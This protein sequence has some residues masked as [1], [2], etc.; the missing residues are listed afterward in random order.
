[1]ASTQFLA[2]IWLDHHAAVLSS[3]MT[4]TLMILLPFNT[5]AF[6]LVQRD[7]LDSKR[8]QDNNDK[9]IPPYDRASLLAYYTFWWVRPTLATA[10][11]KNSLAMTDLP[12]LSKF[13]EP[14]LL[15][16]RFWVWWNRHGKAA[17]PF[18]LLVALIF[19]IQR[20]VFWNSFLHGILFL[21]CMFADPI[22]LNELLKSK[23]SFAYSMV[24]IAGLS[25]SMLVRVSCMEVCF[26]E[27]TRVANN[28]RT[29]LVLVIFKITITNPSES[30]R[31]LAGFLTNLMASDTEKLGQFS[32]GIFALAQWCF[33]VVT[34]PLNL[35]FLHGLV[36]NGAFLAIGVLA[37]GGLLGKNIGDML[38][39]NQKRL[40][41]CR[42]ARSK[43]MKQV[44]RSIKVTKLERLEPM[45][46]V[47]LKDARAVELEQLRNVQYLSAFNNL[48]GALLALS[49][50]LS[51][52]AWVTVVEGRDLDAATAFSALAWI[53]QMQWTTT[54]LPFIFNA[55]STLK[56]SLERVG[57][58][59]K[60]ATRVETVDVSCQNE[61]H[62]FGEIHLQCSSSGASAACL[63]VE[64]GQLVVVIGVTGSGKS[65]LL[66][67]FVTP[68]EG[69]ISCVHGS[70]ALVLQT[71]FLLNASV[72]DNI[73]FGLPLDEARLQDAVQ[74][75]ELVPDLEALPR[76]IL[77]M[78]GPSGVQLS[79]GQKARVCLARALYSDADC[80][81]LDD[82]LSAVDRT[83]GNRIW[84]N[85]VA[86]L[87]AKSK[88]IVLI[89]HQIQFLTRP[90]V[91]KVVLMDNS[92]IRAS[93]KFK[94]LIGN[95]HVARCLEFL[96]EGDLSE[97]DLS[98]GVVPSVHQ[99][100]LVVKE[101][102]VDQPLLTLQEVRD[103]LGPLLHSLR[104][105]PLTD[106]VISDQILIH[107]RSA[108]SDWNSMTETSQKGAVSMSD[109]AY[110]FR[111]FG[112]LFGALGCLILVAFITAFAN[113]FSSVWISYWTDSSS[114]G[115]RYSQVV[116]LSVFGALGG[117]QAVI[118]CVQ[119]ILLTWAAIRA[120]TT[121][122]EEMV[123]KL[124]SA[125]L[126]YF[127]THS[128]GL[129]LNR[130]LQDLGSIDSSV[131]QT[132]LDQIGKTFSILGQFFLILF[133]TPFVMLILPV[134]IAFYTFIINT[135]R[136]A[137]RDTRR[138]ESVARSPVYD[139]FS[140][141][142]NGLETIQC[143]G[144]Q[145]R[146]EAWNVGLVRGMSAA[147]VGNEAVNKWAQA[148]TVQVSCLFYFC[149]GGVGVGLLY[150]GVVS[151]STFGL[152]LLNAAILQRALM[153]FVMGLTN[154]ET[155]FVSVE[156]VAE[157]AKMTSEK[158]D[159]RVVESREWVREGR[160]EICDLRMRYAIN[161]GYVLD[162]VSLRVEAG[163][164]VAVIG[165][166]GCGKSSLLAA[167][168][169]LY[170]PSDGRIL[171]DGVD[172]QT[173]S[174]QTLQ[175]V[176]RVIPQ[177]TVLFDGTIRN[178]ILV[179]RSMADA[180]IWQVLDTVQLKTKVVSLGGLDAEI[181]FGGA[182]FSAGERQLL[183]LARALSS[184][185]PKILLCDEVTSNV[186]LATDDLVL[187]ALLGL[188]ATVVMVMHRLESLKRFDRILMLQ[189]GRVLAYG[190][191]RELVEGN[192][193]VQQFMR[194]ESL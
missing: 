169:Q 31:P 163:L 123:E 143:F 170:P 76:G 38:A 114:D 85:V 110:Y 176:V 26:Y 95:K 51:M 47:Q 46:F 144:A 112:N 78:V 151:M 104:G 141:I 168:A 161:R 194:H 116:Y 99:L 21:T 118:A 119:A 8:W 52:F 183:C 19:T 1:M 149:A 58:F 160:L 156:R 165:R 179:G 2:L 100:D 106:S 23:D 189:E 32:W 105:K 187:T 113:I 167:L 73:V 17:T 188:K 70:V 107:F 69:D 101:E 155:N 88:T 154:L 41:E 10:N 77:T 45:W 157:F 49:I 126:S 53:A 94:D 74:R 4:T 122:H 27:S 81:L 82:I 16:D 93:G 68:K 57:S 125:P 62:G 18:Q 137:A 12:S 56:P 121:I 133:F 22:M 84:E 103:F 150:G 71:P 185:S 91:D 186:D 117:L 130:F 92:E 146:F 148:L 89:T 5:L 177:E 132:M 14:K 175:E 43:V 174:Q 192:A 138:I 166:T 173:V 128:S 66:S 61:Q 80:Y 33:A 97:G 129:I 15:E 147:K 13:D 172:V 63:D 180:N 191:A 181:K 153:D 67:S 64:A 7:V 158:D 182:E 90:E 111:H 124:L 72:K 135:F 29:A 178:N 40:Q 83:T 87:R 36:G 39:R 54:S 65:R 120:S 44:I 55:W 28:V 102:K 164:K 193:D 142:L 3:N 59:L 131:P 24:L 190:D 109:F 115:E 86:H 139:L 9:T 79:G 35:Y 34:L 25:V 171:V 50:P 127:D 20:T 152:V 136:I 162:G 108:A 159:L 96:S 6:L 184:G 98:E 134:V 140:D 42:D 48:F 37:M 145:G 11:A 75:T 30:T 60:T